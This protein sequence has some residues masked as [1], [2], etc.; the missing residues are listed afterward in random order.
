LR[1][2]WRQRKIFFVTFVALC[3]GDAKFQSSIRRPIGKYI[4]P[5]HFFLAGIPVK[6]ASASMLT[7][8]LPHQMYIVVLEMPC[9]FL[10]LNDGIEMVVT[11]FSPELRCSPVALVLNNLIANAFASRRGFSF[12]SS[13]ETLTK[14]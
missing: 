7:F 11:N 14:S 5:H 12:R 3:S 6:I 8:A 13:L 9:E 4:C 10:G 2:L 1:R